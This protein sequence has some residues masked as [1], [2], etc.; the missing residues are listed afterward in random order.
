MLVILGPTN[1]FSSFLS[2]NPSNASAHTRP[3]RSECASMRCS[4]IPLSG[5]FKTFAANLT[6][7]LMLQSVASPQPTSS[8][9]EHKNASILLVFFRIYTTRLPRALLTGHQMPTPRIAS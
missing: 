8:Q 2:L 9:Y 7:Y 6:A 3:D 1:P 4:G 5:Y